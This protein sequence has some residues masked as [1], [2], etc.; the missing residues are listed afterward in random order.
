MR[1]GQRLSGGRPDVGRAAQR[2]AD[3]LA[4][5]LVDRKALR[6]SGHGGEQRRTERGQPAEGCNPHA[7]FEGL[8][9]SIEGSTRSGGRCP[10]MKVLILIMTFSPMS[11]RPSIVA[12]PMCGSSTTLPAR[13]SFSSLGLT[14]GS[15]A[16]TSTPAP[17]TPPRALTRAPACES[18]TPPRAV[19]T[20]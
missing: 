10:S 19:L 1:G 13:A 2:Q 9:H 12:E 18:D 17:P 4:A 16:T 14:A 11:M 3:K 5:K 7:G 20:T 8:D 15:G 6:P